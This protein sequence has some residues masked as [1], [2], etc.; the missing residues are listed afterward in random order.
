WLRLGLPESPRWL[1]HHGRV[2]EAD[3]I[4]TR[5]EARIARDTGARLTSPDAP[6]AEQDRGAAASS[7]RDIF[8]PPYRR[9]TIALAVFNFFQTI[10]FYGFGNWVPKLVSGQGVTVATSLQYSFIIALAFPLGPFL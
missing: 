3:A 8:A 1:A 6:C 10:G 2:D 4:L 7:L 9:R 5:M